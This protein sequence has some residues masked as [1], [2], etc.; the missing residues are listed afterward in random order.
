MPDI[1]QCYGITPYLTMKQEMCL[2]LS[3]AQ[4]CVMKLHLFQTKKSANCT[5]SSQNKYKDNKCLKKIK[6]IKRPY[7]VFVMVSF[8]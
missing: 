4:Q 3:N 7:S 5:E 1:A 2:C 8:Y 6:K